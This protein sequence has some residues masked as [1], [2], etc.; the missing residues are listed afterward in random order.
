MLHSF[1]TYLE[2]SAGGRKISSTQ[3][4]CLNNTWSLTNVVA[5]CVFPHSTHLACPS[6]RPCAPG[7]RDRPPDLQATPPPPALLAP[8]DTLSIATGPPCPP[9][10]YAR[11]RHLAGGRWRAPRHSHSHT[12]RYTLS[13]TQRDQVHSLGKINGSFVDYSGP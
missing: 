5:L 3:W 4:Q 6:S 7:S 11:R 2:C 10:I 8:A 1:F 9:A 13:H 12:H